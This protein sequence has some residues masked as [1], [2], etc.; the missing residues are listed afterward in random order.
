MEKNFRQEDG[1]LRRRIGIIKPAVLK[2]CCRSL[3]MFDIHTDTK[4]NKHSEREL[5]GRGRE[6]WTSTCYRKS[7][8]TL[9]FLKSDQK[10]NNTGSINSEMNFLTPSIALPGEEIGE[11][12]A[13]GGIIP[14]K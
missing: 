5:K 7:F 2:L 14:I 9:S 11:M 10:L 12:K 6:N 1:L 8:Q 4:G 13:G 3:Q